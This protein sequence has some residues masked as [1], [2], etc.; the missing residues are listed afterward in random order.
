MGMIPI[1]AV[2]GESYYTVNAVWDHSWRYLFEK[3]GRSKESG[4]GLLHHGLESSLE[5]MPIVWTVDGA[6]RMYGTDSWL[7]SVYGETCEGCVAMW[8]VFRGFWA[9]KVV[10]GT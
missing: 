2:Y 8:G 10:V 5:H 7:A 4:R 3:G 9:H 6:S 1:I